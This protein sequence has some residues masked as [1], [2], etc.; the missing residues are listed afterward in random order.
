MGDELTVSEAAELTGYTKR[1]L[2][3]L[4]KDGDIEA[5]Q[6]G[7]WLYLLDRGSVEGYA[8]R[9]EALGKKKHAPTR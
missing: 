2:R 1:H 8:R 3:R 7:G 6:V 9:M 5:R 4:A